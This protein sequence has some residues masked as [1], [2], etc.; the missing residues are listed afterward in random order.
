MYP[1]EVG[2]LYVGSGYG[3]DGFVG[4]ITLGLTVV[5]HDVV[6]VLPEIGLGASNSSHTDVGTF[7]TSTTHSL[8]SHLV[9]SPSTH[10]SRV[11]PSPST[12][13]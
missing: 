4:K 8:P 13:G 5:V 7:S 2:W 11:G 1:V 3:L 12:H 6:H 10:K 9:S